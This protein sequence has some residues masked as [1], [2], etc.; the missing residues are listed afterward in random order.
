MPATVY[1]GPCDGSYAK[2]VTMQGSFVSALSLAVTLR[3]QYISE[4]GQSPSPMLS[5]G[6]PLMS[7]VDPAISGGTTYW[8]T[9]NVGAEAYSYLKGQNGALHY[10]LVAI[11]PYGNT[12]QSQPA[13]VPVQ[14]C[15]DWSAAMRDMPL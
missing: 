14:Y 9:I 6:M 2:A 1:Y 13:I 7:A 12:V 8:R 15:P 3:Y 4:N 10:Q 11:D 5:T